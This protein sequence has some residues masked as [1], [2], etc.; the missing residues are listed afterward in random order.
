MLLRLSFINFVAKI[1]FSD[2]FT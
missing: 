2:I 1:D